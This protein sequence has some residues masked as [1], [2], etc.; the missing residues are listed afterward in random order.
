MME[1][2]MG[3]REVLVAE[4]RVKDERARKDMVG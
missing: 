3:M 2:V 1:D 4:M